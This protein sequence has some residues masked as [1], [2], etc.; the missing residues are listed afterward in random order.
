MTDKSEG[1]NEYKTQ[2]R[3]KNFTPLLDTLVEE[4]G[5]FTAAVWGRVWR[6]AQQE[7]GV[8]EASQEKI[9]SEL[10]MTRE[11]VNRHIKKLVS[12]EYLIDHTPKLKNRPHVYAITEKA[13]I[14]ITVEGVINNHSSVIKSHS[15][16]DLKSQSGV[17]KSHAKKQVKKQIKKDTV[18]EIPQ[19]LDTEKFLQTWSEFRKYRE[20]IKKPMTSLAETKML[21][22][23][24]AYSSETAIAMLD[25]SIEN[26]W[27]GVF[28]I[29][30][31][32]NGRQDKQNLPEGI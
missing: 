8:C 4:Y 11:T 26:G 30:A 31:S 7:N 10:H 9:A 19:S 16:S 17:I 22:R 18:I 25:Q 1:D 14:A 24:S 29:K 2:A 32:R 12:G 27:Q 20:E 21:K 15:E 3:I 28:E 13:Q 23:L 6:Y 5:V